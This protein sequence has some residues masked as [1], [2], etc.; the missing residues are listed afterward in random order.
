MGKEKPQRKTNSRC[1]NLSS[2]RL[3]CVL[4][5]PQNEKECVSVSLTFLTRRQG[6]MRESFL[7]CQSISFAFVLAFVSCN[8]KVIQYFA[9]VQEFSCQN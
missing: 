8:R 5:I 6:K 7:L 2:Y 9:F 3:L 4:K 1:V